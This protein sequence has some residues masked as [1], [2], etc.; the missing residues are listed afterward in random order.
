[1]KGPL[2]G[3]VSII[4]SLNVM[5]FCI[6][7]FWSWLLLLLYFI[8]HLKLK[9]ALGSFQMGDLLLW[10]LIM[11]FSGLLACLI[12]HGPA[13]RFVGFFNLK[14]NGF[15]FL[16]YLIF[17]FLKANCILGPDFGYPFHCFIGILI[18]SLKMFSTLWVCCWIIILFVFLDFV[19]I[20]FIVLDF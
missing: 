18:G 2:L 3:Q 1:M 5:G 13:F 15:F 14:S 9:R 8:W 4:G 16:Y 7:R 6:M 11:A 12:L 20:F 10:L 19:L 17:C